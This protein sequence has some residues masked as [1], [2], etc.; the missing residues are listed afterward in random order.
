[1]LCDAITRHSGKKHSH[2]DGNLIGLCP[3]LE[4]GGGDGLQRGM[5]ECEK[6]NVFSALIVLVVNLLCALVKAHQTVHFS[7]ANVYFR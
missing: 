5:R 7:K 1:M 2:R 4:P 3:Q 6:M